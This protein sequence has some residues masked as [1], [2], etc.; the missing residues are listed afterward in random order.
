M[1]EHEG[2]GV[3]STPEEFAFELT[4]ATTH[5][6]SCV[7]CA[8]GIVDLIRK[9]DAEVAARAWDE[10]HAVAEDNFVHSDYCG[11]RCQCQGVHGTTNPYR[12][13][14]DS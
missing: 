7:M 5:D 8:S 14:D 4:E 1:S 11:R 10:G 13:E 2:R 3:M 6:L 12:I 9:R